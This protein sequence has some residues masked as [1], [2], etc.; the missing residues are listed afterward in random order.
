LKAGRI[1]EAHETVR[2]IH[3]L[4]QA[5]QQ[6]ERSRDPQRVG[7]LG[8]GLFGVYCRLSP[9]IT[10]HLA[11]A[12]VADQIGSAAVYDARAASVD[13][14]DFLPTACIQFYTHMLNPPRMIE[15]RVE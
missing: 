6:E 3:A 7:D 12:Y 10:G 4:S 1:I 8:V 13:P 2:C 15:W 5:L 11:C 9:N 14:W